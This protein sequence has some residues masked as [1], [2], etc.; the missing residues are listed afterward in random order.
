[1]NEAN[2]YPNWLEGRHLKIAI[3]LT[4]L[5]FNYLGR[6]E[7]YY[8]K[9]S[10]Y[11]ESYAEWAFYLEPEEIEL[12]A[13]LYA[14]EKN[15][16]AL[17]AIYLDPRSGITGKQVLDAAKNAI[18][19]AVIRSFEE[20]AI[21]DGKGVISGIITPSSSLHLNVVPVSLVNSMVAM[22]DGRI[23][24]FSSLKQEIY[25]QEALLKEVGQFR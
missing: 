6:A 4:N 23:D 20:S 18:S 15:E 1:M 24:L 9:R 10:W 5:G 21:S 17:F 16:N 11:V 8:Y 19:R 3:A 14:D 13:I 2:N 7:S 12:L 25:T 22:T